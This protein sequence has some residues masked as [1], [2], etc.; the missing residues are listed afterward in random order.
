M[1]RC[2]LTREDKED[3]TWEIAL[4]ILLY[5][6]EN[7]QAADTVEGILHWWLLERTIVEEQQAVE[8]ALDR[9]VELNLIIDMQAADA[10]RHYHLNSEQI[11]MVRKLIREAE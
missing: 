10:H 2:D 3:A 11:E 8:R 4:K 1:K 6:A 9:L 7:P 5:L